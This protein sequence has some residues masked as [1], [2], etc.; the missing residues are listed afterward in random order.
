[1]K[2]PPSRPQR[3]ADAIAECRAAADKVEAAASEL[4]DALSD[5]R[6]VQSEYSEWRDSMDGKFAGSALAEKLDAIADL[7]LEVEVDVS[8][9][10]E[11]IDNAEGCDLPLG[12]GRD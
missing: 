6:D 9:A 4:N 8:N 11:A 7:D 2:R 5:L 1:M 10:T 3:W 12:F